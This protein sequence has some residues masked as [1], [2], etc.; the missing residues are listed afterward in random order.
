MKASI[1]TIGD[2]IL[3]GSILDTNASFM[4][5]NAVKEGLE[6]VNILS[7]LDQ[8]SGI[9]KA[10][11]F[12]EKTA[13]FIFITGGL[14]PTKDDITVKTLAEYLNVPLVFDKAT[15]LNITKML[16]DRFIKNIQISEESCSFPKG[17]Q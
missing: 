16:E 5:I 8:R 2:E 7:V 17:V 10:L 14:G 12:L 13:D 9:I 15:H 6:I 4:A 1:L 3:N 11:A